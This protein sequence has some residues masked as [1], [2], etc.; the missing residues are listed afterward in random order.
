MEQD[1]ICPQRKTILHKLIKSLSHCVRAS[2]LDLTVLIWYRYQIRSVLQVCNLWRSPQVYTCFYVTLHKQTHTLAGHLPL[3]KGPGTIWDRRQSCRVRGWLAVLRCTGSRSPE[4]HSDRSESNC[5]THAQSQDVFFWRELVLVKRIG[6][7][8]DIDMALFIRDVLSMYY[9]RVRYQRE[10]HVRCRIIRV[11]RVF[12]DMI[13][14]CF[15]FQLTELR[16][17]RGKLSRIFAVGLLEAAGYTSAWSLWFSH[18][19]ILT[20]HAIKAYILTPTDPRLSGIIYPTSTFSSQI[21]WDP[22]SIS[23]NY[24][25]SNGIQDPLAKFTVESDGIM[26]PIYIL[27]KVSWDHRFCN[28][29]HTQTHVWLPGFVIAETNPVT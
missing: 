17:W 21:I 13:S 16:E 14:F 7:Y 1:P 2:T 28:E 20:H 11:R 27:L 29:I 3:T 26:D 10:T 19:N 8:T 12:L 4:G 25:G 18:N 5:V 15:D 9:F 24:P 6:S 22:K 23:F